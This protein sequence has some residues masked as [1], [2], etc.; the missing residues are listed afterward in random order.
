MSCQ[1]VTSDFPD[2][3]CLYPLNELY[4][5]NLS[6]NNDSIDYRRFCMRFD[7]VVILL[8]FIMGASSSLAEQQAEEAWNRTQD[9]AYSHISFSNNSGESIEDA[10]VIINATGEEDG[11]DSEYYYLE[12]RFGIQEIDWELVS[13]SLLSGEGDRYYDKMDIRLSAGEM[14]SIYFDITDFYGKWMEELNI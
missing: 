3:G 14:I 8:L 5:K 10:I 13:Q 4:K 1:K 6:A 11:V 2:L 12:K 7:L 9:L